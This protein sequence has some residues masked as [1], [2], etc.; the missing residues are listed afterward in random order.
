MSRSVGQR[1]GHV[2]AM[3]DGWTLRD[4]TSHRDLHGPRPKPARQGEEGLGGPQGTSSQRPG[5]TCYLFSVSC[6]QGTTY[7]IDNCVL[8]NNSLTDGLLSTYYDPG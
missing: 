4:D 8:D 7:L 2:R 3:H 5:G 6:V 1:Y